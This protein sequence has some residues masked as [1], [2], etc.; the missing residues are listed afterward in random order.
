MPI[1]LSRTIPMSK[2]FSRSR[3]LRH[4]EVQLYKSQWLDHQTRNSRVSGSS[5]TRELQTSSAMIDVIDIEP[6]LVPVSI[7]AGLVENTVRPKK[8]P[9][10]R[11]TR[12]YL[13]EPA[14]PRLFFIGVFIIEVSIFKKNG[15][16]PT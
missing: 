10:F 4:N 7:T 8:N 5:R 9:V 13:S 12:P 14:D 16:D 6:S 1:W 11:A 3:P 15:A 2:Y